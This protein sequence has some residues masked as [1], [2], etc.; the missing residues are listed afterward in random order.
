M[1]ADPPLYWNSVTITYHLPLIT[2]YLSLLF[3]VGHQAAAFH[4]LFEEIRKWPGFIDLFGPGRGYLPLVHVDRDTVSLFKRFSGFFAC[5]Y[6]QPYVDRVPVKY[7][8]KTFSYNTRYPCRFYRYRR[9]FAAGTASK[10]I[11]CNYYIGICMRY[12]DFDSF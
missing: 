4:Y 3:R 5:E 6:R 1:I 8:G 10:I 9:V 7:P 2:Y 12:G 11:T